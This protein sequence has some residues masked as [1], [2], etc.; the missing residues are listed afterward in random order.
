MEGMKAGIGVVWCVLALGAT[1]SAAPA[2]SEAPKGSSTRGPP[3]GTDAGGFDARPSSTKGAGAADASSPAV[4]P[5][6]SRTQGAGGRSAT[7]VDAA[8]FHLDATLPDVA[9]SYRGPETDAAL[10]RDSACAS[11]TTVAEPLPLDLYVMLDRSGSMNIPKPL[12]PATG[13]DCDVGDGTVSRWCFAINALAGFFSSADSA[14]TGVA[15]QFFPGNDCGRTRPFGDNCC[16]EGDCC[17]G[18]DDAV[19][20]VPLAPLPETLDALTGAL[21]DQVPRG[22]TTPIEPALRG[23]LDWALTERTAERNVALVLIT[24]GAATGCDTSTEALTSLVREHHDRDGLRTFLVGM[25]GADF[26]LLEALADAGGSPEHRDFCPGGTRPCRSYNV[27]NG[28]PAAFESAL[29]QIRETAVS[30][31]LAM[32]QTDAGIIDPEQVSLRLTTRGNTEPIERVTGP[33]ECGNVGGF[34]YDDEDSPERIELCPTS[35]ARRRQPRARLDV[36]LGCL[37]G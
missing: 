19:P 1:V 13:G 10:S 36:L 3:S 34:Y 6:A 16:R 25:S 5:D 14:G 27:G 21:D 18:A 29:A 20:A 30:C 15:L 37:Q 17:L 11:A 4:R 8:Q 35:C 2:C 23:M 32:P 33:T 28:D 7:G 12:P 22:T 31:A 24:D 26:T 9:F